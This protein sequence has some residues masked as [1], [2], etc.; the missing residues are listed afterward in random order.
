MLLSA[1][2]HIDRSMVWPRK[3]LR[4]VGRTGPAPGEAEERALFSGYQ[5]AH[6]GTSGVFT[7]GQVLETLAEN[8]KKSGFLGPPPTWFIKAG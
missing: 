7:P 4:G 8:F 5:K 6:V 1:A 2:V 3:S